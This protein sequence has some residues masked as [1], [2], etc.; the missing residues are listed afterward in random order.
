MDI[1]QVRSS[2]WI[3]GQDEGDKRRETGQFVCIPHLFPHKSERKYNE[4]ILI[5]KQHPTEQNGVHHI[6]DAFIRSVI[7]FIHF[8]EMYQKFHTT[9]EELAKDIVIYLPEKVIKSSKKHADSQD[10]VSSPTR[11]RT[12]TTSHIKKCSMK[13]VKKSHVSSKKKTRK[14]QDLM[15]GPFLNFMHRSSMLIVCKN[16][17]QLPTLTVYKEGWV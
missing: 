4:V 1:P 2:F 11:K 13:A 9:V 8:K 15:V 10:P 17:D 3:H 16:V 12:K 6:I 5:E 14:Q 7:I